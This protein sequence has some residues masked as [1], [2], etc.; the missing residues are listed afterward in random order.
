MQTDDTGTAVVSYVR[1]ESWMYN[2]VDDNTALTIN[3]TVVAANPGGS[4]VILGDAVLTDAEV[5]AAYPAGTVEYYI[6][7]GTDDE[8]SDNLAEFQAATTAL[9]NEDIMDVPPVLG[10]TATGGTDAYSVLWDAMLAEIEAIDALANFGVALAAAQLV[11]DDLKVIYENEVLLLVAAQDVLAA[12]VAAQIPFA[13]ADVAAAIVVA[14][15][16]VAVADA[17]ADV[18]DADADLAALLGYTPA[19]MQ[20]EIDDKEHEIVENNIDLAEY[21]PMLAD[22]IVKL[23]ELEAALLDAGLGI[24]F[25]AIIDLNNQ[26]DA[27]DDEID[28][29]SVMWY[30]MDIVISALGMDNA[31]LQMTLDYM[32]MDIATCQDAIEAQQVMIAV[33][34]VDEAAAQAAI[35][36]LENQLAEILAQVDGYNA[37]AT[38][39]WDLMLAALAA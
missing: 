11:Y 7:V 12:A 28:A 1:V 9:G 23:A 39:F 24:E 6:E 37:L 17:D 30:Q 20:D 10:D 19:D 8:S 34:Q 29:L 38:K 36:Q 35:T 25:A 31:Y 33:G 22:A 5:A 16:I 14:D 2:G 26:I 13:D 4:N 32:L 3:A 15:A 21:E 27:L 18:V